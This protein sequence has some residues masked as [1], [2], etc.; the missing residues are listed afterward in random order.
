MSQRKRDS[1]FR[2]AQTKAKN[3]GLEHFKR[4]EKPRS[5]Q[6]SNRYY[7]FT[8]SKKSKRIVC[9]CSKRCWEKFS[10]NSL[11][12]L[13]KEFYATGDIKEQKNFI[14][15]FC[16][17]LDRN[18]R[19]KYYYNLPR[20]AA[21]RT[22][23]H[24]ESLLI[25]VCR[26]FF[27]SALDITFAFIDYT[28]NKMQSRLS[29]YVR[30]DLRGT[31][32]NRKHA[33]SETEFDAMCSTISGIQRMPSHYNRKRSTGRLYLYKTMSIASFYREYKDMTRKQ[34]EEFH[35]AANDLNSQPERMPRIYSY[36]T[37]RN[38]IHFAYPNLSF[39][40]IER[41]KCKRY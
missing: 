11:I 8:P 32:Q 35:N 12:T 1:K 10:S 13:F 17:C 38:V 2:I 4:V 28:I 29:V 39:K 9:K 30:N 19:K 16:F 34:I 36:E 18:G 14:C 5:G 23:T 6:A 20:S 37:F 24:E 15:R 25:P 22:G 31:H 33:I 27:L 40:R 41:D 3:S 26:A 21:N 7:L